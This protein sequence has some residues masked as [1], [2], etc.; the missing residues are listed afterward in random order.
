MLL[1]EQIQKSAPNNNF[2]FNPKGL[3]N[4]FDNS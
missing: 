3:N 2:W 1:H 4:F